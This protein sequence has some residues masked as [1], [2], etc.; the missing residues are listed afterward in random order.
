MA[1]SSSSP[2]DELGVRLNAERMLAEQRIGWCSCGD[3]DGAGRP[4]VG[5]GVCDLPAD[6]TLHGARRAARRAQRHLR[7]HVGGGR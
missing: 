4:L 7:E 6:A 2:V 1:L 5:C 3:R